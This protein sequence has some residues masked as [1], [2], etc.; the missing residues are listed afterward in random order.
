MCHYLI[1]PIEKQ[2]EG[3]KKPIEKLIMERHLL[4][5]TKQEK[6]SQIQLMNAIDHTTSL[7]STSQIH[8]FMEE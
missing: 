5:K 1:Y 4:K 7:G 8:P 3:L 6:E 2:M